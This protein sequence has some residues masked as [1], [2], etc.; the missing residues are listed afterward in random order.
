[1]SRSGVMALATQFL[2]RA[3]QV[4][5]RT[6]LMLG[7]GLVLMFVLL[8]WV[9]IA[10]MGWLYGQVR[11]WSANAPDATRQAVTTMEQQVEQVL[12]GAREEV[13]ASLGELVQMLKPQEQKWREVS[14]ND[15]APVQRFPGLTRTYWHRE[16][17]HLAVHYEGH[18]EYAA[19]LDHYLRGFAA[20]GHTHQLQG[21]SPEL[22]THLWTL[23]NKGYLVRFAAKPG[24]VVA[25]EIETTQGR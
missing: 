16:G 19:V 15:F 3:L 6:W 9:A 25:V 8:V 14:G 17:R 2:P 4:R 12:P 20:L 10:L 21:A 5:R 7:V 1:M 22:E 13:T 18:A 23:D 11:S 24:G